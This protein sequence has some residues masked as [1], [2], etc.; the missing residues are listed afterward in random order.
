MRRSVAILASLTAT[1]ALAGPTIDPPVPAG[2]DPGG[3]AVA[4]IG[5][6]LDYREGDIAQRFARDGEGEIIGYD[7]QDDDKRPYKI[8]H[9]YETENF[10]HPG[11]AVARILLT[12]AE[13]CRLVAVRTK[14]D[15]AKL[16]ATAIDFAAHT[17]ARII[18]VQYPYAADGD[19]VLLNSAA[20]R[21]P[22]KLFIVPVGEFNSNLDLSPAAKAGGAPNLIVVAA[23]SA[24]GS[25]FDGSS[26]GKRAVDVATNAEA[27]TNF[28]A[29]GPPFPFKPDGDIAMARLAALAARLLAIRPDLTA[30]DL[31]AHVLRLARQPTASS[32]KATRKGFIAEPWRPFQVAKRWR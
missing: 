29:A 4:I 8:M 16:L 14:F 27:L 15:D 21:Y 13:A 11:T 19:I 17:P 18:A 1:S 7:F 9:I 25:I 32:G 12:E 20:R 22:D 3:I 26:W 24:D 31:K 30:N 23:A 28:G 6:G 5:P 10:S 2:T